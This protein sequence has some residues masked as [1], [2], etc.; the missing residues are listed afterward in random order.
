MQ[1][2][3]YTP[4]TSPKHSV[5]RQAQTR[6]QRR[7]E[8]TPQ[9]DTVD[10]KRQKQK[11]RDKKN[12]M[13]GFI[14]GATVMLAA[15][16]GGKAVI[17]NAL[18]PNADFD[19]K[20]NSIVEVADFCDI[21]P[22]AITLVNHIDEQT[23]IDK[24]VLPEKIDLLEEKIN[25]LEEEL[26]NSTDSFD[27]SEL[28]DELKELKEKQN[29]QNELAQVYV[30]DGSKY[31]YIIPN[32][33]GISSEDLKEA[34]NIE[35]GVLRKYNDLS[36]TW[37]TDDSVEVHQGYKDYTGAIIPYEGIKVPLKELN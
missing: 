34:F 33:E 36:Y 8:R 4:I 9:Q 12:Q 19:T 2:I 21:D 11:Q 17:N 30:V 24:I 18:S 29:L 7:L 22:R 5:Q 14:L 1:E 26:K 13:Q 20:G 28:Q 15:L 31:A 16:T 3:K 6:P 32:E 35:D 27:Q 23:T 25:A 37:E 10:I